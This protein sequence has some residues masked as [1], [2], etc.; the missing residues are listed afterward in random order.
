MKNIFVIPIEPIETRY[1]CEWYEH[2]PNLLKSQAPN[3]V[4][5]INIE[6]TEVPPIPSQGAFLDFGATNV[7]KSSQLIRIADMFRTG[8]VTSGDK[9]L[10]TDFWNPCI[11]QVK[12]MSEL[13]NIPVVIH[14]L[15]HAGSYD[16]Q[17]FLGRLIK[18]KRWTNS[19]EKAIFHAA[20]YHW[21][22]TDYHVKLFQDNVFGRDGMIWELSDDEVINKFCR[23]GWPMDYMPSTLKKYNTVTKENVIIFPHRLA[24]EKQ[25]EI[26][27]DL[28]VSLPEY[29]F[30]VCQ[31]Q[32]LS[33]TE[34]H[35]LLARS[36][37]MFSANLQETLGISPWES[38]LAGCA[39]LVPDR[40]SYRETFSRKEF[41][42]PSKWTEDY[43]S[44]LKHKNKIITRIHEIM[45]NYE[46]LLPV[47]KS[48][49]EYQKNNYFTAT[50][51]IHHLLTN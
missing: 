47:I 9:F 51:L 15:V 44:Y 35:Q 8:K 20:D 4:N 29:E 27:L 24:P 38:M 23:T 41:K 10:F 42:Y 50:N 21:F 19:T 37:L 43:T 32:K 22:A 7:Y 11:I 33:K 28:K 36:K 34:Y 49:A 14:T 3:N 1:T 13:L 40:L 16:P 6:G 25:P 31:D 46:D 2:I 17:D 18:D 26:F 5:V 12:Y 30:I 48:E 39:C 45:D